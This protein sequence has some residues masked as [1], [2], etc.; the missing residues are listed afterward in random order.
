MPYKSIN[1]Q[2][3]PMFDIISS[4]L[5][6]RAVISYRRHIIQAGGQMI[7]KTIGGRLYKL[8]GNWD[9]NMVFSPV[10]REDDEV[11]IF[12]PKELKTLLRIGRLVRADRQEKQKQYN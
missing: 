3:L 7:V 8:V 6:K 4:C 1:K 9:A 10:D 5:Y 2:R 12:S 11:M